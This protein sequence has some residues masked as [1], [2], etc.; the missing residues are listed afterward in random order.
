MAYTGGTVAA[1]QCI[2][3]LTALGALVDVY[4][5]KW[6]STHPDFS[7][8]SFEDLA[9]YQLKSNGLCEGH[10]LVISTSLDLTVASTLLPAAHP[11][12]AAYFAEEVRNHRP[13]LIFINLATKQILCI[14]LGRKNQLFGFAIG[15]DD[16]SIRDGTVHDVI[17]PWLQHVKDDPTVLFMREFLQYDYAGI[18]PSLI[19]SLYEFGVCARA[20][21]YL[22]LNPEIIEQIL[23]KGPDKDGMFDI[24]G[25]M[26]SLDDAQ[27]VIAEFEKVDEWGRENLSTLQ[28]LFPE[29]T[30]GDLNTQDY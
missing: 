25:E 8:F 16:V 24:D 27:N 2:T 5:K 6:L 15:S 18:V 4:S 13:D 3:Q 30:W 26:M 12:F 11:S 19:E 20:W 28:D 21:D 29:L 7:H 10:L 17:R 1:R 9:E 14:G 23:N 22:P